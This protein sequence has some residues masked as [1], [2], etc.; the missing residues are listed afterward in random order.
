M[1]WRSWFRLL[2]GMDWYSRFALAAAS[3]RPRV[4]FLAGRLT[5]GRSVVVRASD[6]NSARR[7]HR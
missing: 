5:Q 6:C 3:N 1:Q 7:A 2:P 4:E